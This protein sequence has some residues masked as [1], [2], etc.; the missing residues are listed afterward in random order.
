[1]DYL[2]YRAGKKLLA[3]QVRA[4]TGLIPQGKFIHCLFCILRRNALIECWRVGSPMDGL[5]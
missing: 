2:A 4:L 3:K 1:M 5:S